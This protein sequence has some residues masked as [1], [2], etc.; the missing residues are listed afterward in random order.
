MQSANKA[1]SQ[2][3]GQLTTTQQTG[4]QVPTDR[5]TAALVNQIFQELRVTCTAWK[6]PIEGDLQ[7]YVNEYKRKLL[8]ALVREGVNDWGQVQKGL[9][10]ITSPFLPNP[11]QFAID[12]KGGGEI[13][14]SWG[15]GAHKIWRKD[16]R[17]ESCTREERN[18]RGMKALNEIRGIL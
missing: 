6:N 13:T 1:I 15:T 12:C 3:V 14:G 2:A 10:A 7:S 11:N 16:R 4:L 17:L 8:E 18:E 9:A 5:A